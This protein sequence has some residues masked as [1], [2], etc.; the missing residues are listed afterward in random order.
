MKAP[1]H[2]RGPADEQDIELL[3]IGSQPTSTGAGIDGLLP[4]TP[5]QMPIPAKELA[6]L[7]KEFYSFGG[8]GHRAGLSPGVDGYGNPI[9]SV[10]ERGEAILKANLLQAR[11]KTRN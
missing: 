5:R 4:M 7:K 3:G 8:P 1:W 6:I 9:I 11:R 10:R 2:C